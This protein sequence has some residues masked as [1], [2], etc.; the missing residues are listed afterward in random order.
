MII[1]DLDPGVTTEQPGLTGALRDYGR[2]LSQGELAYWPVLLGLI[3]IWGVFQAANDRFLSA[4][5]LT[6][7]MLQIAA[8]GTIAIGVVVVLLIREIDLS[9]AQVSG[10]SAAIMA[11]IS[12][13]GGVPGPFAMLI[14]L[15]AGAAIGLFHGL[16]VTRFRVPS[17]VV[18]LAGLLGWL[19]VQLSVLGRTGTVN[20]TDR[21]ILGLAGTFFPPVLGWLVAVA[22]IGIVGAMGVLDRR[23]RAAA[24]LRLPGARAPA[25]RLV[26]VSAV[27]LA[28]M[29]VFN[30]DRGLPLSVMIFLVLVVLVD[31]L[32]TRMRFGRHARAV[33]GNPEA[34]RRAGIAVDRI[35]VLVFVLASTMA[36]AG[37]ILGAS[38]LLAVNQSSGGSDLLL[39]VIAAA[40]IGGTSLFGGR[41]SA[42]SALLGALVIGSI[43]NGMDLLAVSSNVKFMV[44]GAVL[45][46]AATIDAVSRR[47]RLT[48]GR[49]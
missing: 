45:L 32:T 13:K 1:Q 16:W 29:A 9:I 47:G 31:L 39:N 36:A 43:A 24:G 5:N 26:V 41:G 7:L 6:N 48:A 49:A 35:R 30:A 46:V 27:V 18:T 8:T 21:T 34:A 28:A 3:L 19:G 2:R 11:V 12:A 42:W 15:A 14:A 20:L 33:G 4:V 44:T 38:R 25:A 17:F 10:L 23:R 37:G 40:V 22:V